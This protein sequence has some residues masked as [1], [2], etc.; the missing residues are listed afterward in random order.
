MW[1]AIDAV[2]Q[3]FVF[4][5]GEFVCV[6]LLSDKLLGFTGREAQ[7]QKADEK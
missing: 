2:Y 5:F 4:D 6:A 1:K 3:L 7:K